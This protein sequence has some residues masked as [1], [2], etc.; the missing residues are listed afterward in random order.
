MPVDQILGRWR[1]AETDDISPYLQKM[2]ILMSFLNVCLFECTIKCRINTVNFEVIF[3]I[4][5]Y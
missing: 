5:E 2:G 1:L 4:Y 3:E